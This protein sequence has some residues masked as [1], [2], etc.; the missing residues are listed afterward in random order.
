M[1]K[2][3]T[4]QLAYIAVLSTPDSGK[5]HTWNRQG[6]GAVGEITW[7]EAVVD[8]LSS[9]KEAYID[10]DYFLSGLGGVNSK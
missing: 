6:P 2:I 5:L 1:I 9:L 10:V 3:K 4:S 8:K 7:T